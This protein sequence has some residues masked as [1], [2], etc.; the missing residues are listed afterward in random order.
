MSDVCQIVP[1]KIYRPIRFIN[2]AIS[3]DGS[4]GALNDKS[5]NLINLDLVSVSI[6][7]T[8]LSKWPSPFLTFYCNS[9]A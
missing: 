2:A 4:E 3:L 8:D 9:S 6:E 7:N 5:S 1:D